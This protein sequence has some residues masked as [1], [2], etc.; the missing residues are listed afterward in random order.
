MYRSVWAPL[1]SAGAIGLVSI[2]DSRAV[3]QTADDPSD[4]P[5]VTVEQKAEPAVTP[6][7]AKKK[8]KQAATAPV[9]QPPAAPSTNRKAPVRSS[10]TAL[11]TYD[12]ALDLPDLELPPGTILT[13][14]GPVYGYQAL[15]AMSATK[16]ATPIDQIPQSIQ[17][18]PKSLIEDQ[19]NLTVSETVQNVS[20]VQGPNSR[21][22]GDTQLYPYTIR[23]FGAQAWLDGLV[24][25]FSAGDR[26]A[27]AN[28]ERIE[29]LKGPNAILY[30]GGAGAPIGGAI[31]IVSKMPTNKA[32]GEFGFTFGSNNYL[33]PYFDVNQP[34]SIDGTVLFRITGEYTGADSFIDVLE[35]DRYSI[36]PTLTIT[37]KTDTTLT[38]QGRKSRS[39]QQTYQGLPA[40]GTVAGSFRIDRDMFIGPSDIPR[41]YS[42]VEGVTV[43]LDHELNEIW[44]TNV[45]ARWSRSAFEQ[46]TQVLVGSDAAG[47]VPAFPLSTW[48]L[49]NSELQQEQEEFTV[50]PSAQARFS[51]GQT[52]NTFLVGADYSRVRDEG[53][54]TA[55]YLGFTAF[56]DLLDPHFTVPY[57]DPAPPVLPFFG[58]TPFNDTTNT[59]V[60]RGAYAQ[61]QS[62]LFDRVHV[63][64][65]VRSAHVEIEQIERASG[66]PQFTVTDATKTLPRAGAVVDLWSGLSVYA[67][68][69]EGMRAVPRQLPGGESLPEFSKQREAGLKFNI[70][71][72]LSGTIAYF[73]I[74]RENVVVNLG[75]LAGIALANQEAYGFETDVIWQPSLNWQVL[76]SYGYTNAEFADALL[77]VPAGNKFAGVPEHSGRLWVNYK[78]DEPFLKGWSIGAGIY[79]AS[80]QFVDTANQFQTSGYFTVDAKVGYETDT[81]AATFNV[82]NLT[83]EEYFVPYAFLGGQVA[84]GDERSYYGTVVV[85]Y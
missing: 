66:F 7:P 10:A 60:T 18:I 78:P 50:N 70:N 61:L 15:S 48:Y 16:T 19:N 32:S 12:P 81:F 84:P 5:P 53:F 40:T 33:Q 44:S 8:K 29:V 41:G 45:K 46:N 57:A 68:Y 35:Q 65:G 51:L 22:L 55:D 67:S 52:R 13:T 56:V 3:A 58:Y 82:K 17:V 71:N 6:Q 80:S 72:E 30:G 34:L 59:F 76:G 63:L 43:T 23:G 54:L 74:D 11:G 49:A 37:N 9:A 64:A 4:L 21:S 26:D 62:T 79:A 75:G 28:V 1:I 31:N 27:L 73:E 14:A 77:G 69:S 83:D 38:I 47:A 24:M 2:I 36:N 39:E 85:R 42:E 25:P 20:N